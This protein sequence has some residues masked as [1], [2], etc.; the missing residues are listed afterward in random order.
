[1]WLSHLRIFF[2]TAE[3]PGLFGWV[4]YNPKGPYKREVGVIVRGGDVRMEAGVL[5][6]PVA[7]CY[8]AGFKVRK[9]PWAKE[10]KQLLE[11]KKYKEI[12]SPLELL[13]IMLSFQQL[14]FRLIRD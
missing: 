8:A 14:D 2:E 11:A 7:S 6:R 13:Q 5:E 4:E 9:G 10:Y 3:C 1:M 12:D